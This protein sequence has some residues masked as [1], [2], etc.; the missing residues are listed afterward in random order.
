MSGKP[1][2]AAKVASTDAGSKINAAMDSALSEEEK[3]KVMMKMTDAQW[4]QTQEEMSHDARIN[5]PGQKGVAKKA[6]IPEGEPPHG[7]VCFRCG[8]KGKSPSFKSF[9]LLTFAR[10]LDSSMSNKRRCI[11]RQQS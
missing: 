11:I 2:A 3:L 5:V 9:H 8:E 10:S 1:P 4:R 7:Y 6:N